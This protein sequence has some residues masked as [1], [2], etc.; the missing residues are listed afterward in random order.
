MNKSKRTRLRA[1]GWRMRTTSE[2]VDLS[3]AESEYIELKI[4]RV[5]ALRARRAKL[6]W[7]QQELASELGSSQ[8]RV[9]KLESGDATVSLDLILH[10]LLALG[11]T[12]KDLARL[13]ARSAA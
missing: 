2:F 6:G 7:T 1:A 5:D 12:R 10:A 9:A 11:A 13:I 4:A 3:H 8:S